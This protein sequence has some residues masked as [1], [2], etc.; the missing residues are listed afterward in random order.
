M[1][2]L[3][4]SIIYRLVDAARA[5]FKAS[6]RK[7]FEVLERENVEL[8][9]QVGKQVLYVH[10]IF[11]LRDGLSRVPAQHS[12]AGGEGGGAGAEGEGLQAAGG[13]GDHQ[14]DGGANAGEAGVTFSLF[15]LSTYHF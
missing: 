1:C 15:S 6:V 10:S 5:E 4:P 13:A 8:R 9:K 3:T 11:L 2:F 7:D 12:P 14:Q